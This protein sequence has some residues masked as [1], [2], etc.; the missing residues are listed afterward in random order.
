MLFPAI[1]QEDDLIKQASEI[2]SSLEQAADLVTDNINSGYLAT[3]LLRYFNLMMNRESEMSMDTVQETSAWDLSDFESFLQAMPNETDA[4]GAALGILRLHVMYGLSSSDILHGDIKGHMSRS[5]TFD[6]TLYLVRHIRHRSIA[7]MG[8]NVYNL[9]WNWITSVM[10]EEFDIDEQKRQALLQRALGFLKS[11]PCNYTE[12]YLK[13]IKSLSSMHSNLD[14]L[15]H[16]SYILKQWKGLDNVCPILSKHPK[17]ELYDLL[18][19]Y[20]KLCRSENTYTNINTKKHTKPS[21][22][23]GCFLLHNNDPILLLAPV[24]MEILH[25]SRPQ[26]ALIH[27]AI[28]DKQIRGLKNFSRT[29]VQRSTVTTRAGLV[30]SDNKISQQM[31]IRDKQV[32]QLL[33]SFQRRIA[34][35]TQLNSYGLEPLHVANYGVGG[36]YDVHVDFVFAEASSD[37]DFDPDMFDQRLVSVVTYLNDVEDG[38]ATVF[39]ELGIKVN[40]RKGTA[41]MFYSLFRNGTGNF[42]SRHAS[43]P[44]VYGNKWIAVQWARRSYHYTRYPCTLDRFE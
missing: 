14:E 38:G 17:G 10:H 25:D 22:T 39:P 31:K 7:T 37:K 24:K 20:R 35:L 33:S 29:Q 6:E 18:K 4:V 1:N 30:P 28:S 5:L 11:L 36:Q 42:L 12:Q 2:V 13:I 27:D 44:V 34:A 41:V 15:S 16:Y 32:K 26:I 23:C 8:I 9:T 40:P 19:N 43:C 3:T 21:R